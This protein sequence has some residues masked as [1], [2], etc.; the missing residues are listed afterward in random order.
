MRALSGDFHCI[1][2]VHYA[3]LVGRFSLYRDRSLCTPC[4]E[5]FDAVLITDVS[6]SS[7][8]ICLI[9]SV[10]YS[11]RNV[12]EVFFSIIIYLWLFISH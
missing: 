1:G 5:I 3:R 2:I 7:Q 8:F 6:L 9:F 11:G 10:S 4:R 12:Q